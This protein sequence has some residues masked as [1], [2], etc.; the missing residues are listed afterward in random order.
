MRKINILD[1]TLRD[2]GFVNDWNFGKG[3]IES[4]ISRLDKA[5]IDIIELGFLDERRQPDRTGQF[6]LI[7]LQ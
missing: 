1:C 5:G 7:R 3:S 6:S 2:G 4:I